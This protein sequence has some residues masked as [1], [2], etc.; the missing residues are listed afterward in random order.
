M[1]KYIGRKIGFAIAKEA[2]R[3]TPEADPDFW[4]PVM[5]VKHQNK[6]EHARFEAAIGTVYGASD[7]ELM[8]EWAEDGV[9]VYIGSEHFPLML[10]GLLGTLSTQVE[11]PEDDVHT[12]T[13]SLAET[14]QHQALTLFI[15]E[16]NGD[17]QFGLGVVSGIDINFERGKIL[18]YTANL[19]SKKGVSDT[20]TASVPSENIFRPQDFSVKIATNL[21]GLSGASAFDVISCNISFEKSIEPDDVLGDVAPQD[22]LNTVLTI[23]GSITLRYDANTYRDLMLANTH[24]AMRIKLTNTGVT[25]GLA[26]NPDIEI[27]LAKVFFTEDSF[28]RSLN[29]IVQETLNFEA[30]Y[31][32][33][34]SKF[35]DIIVINETSAY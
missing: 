1:T 35:G 15:D 31:S 34:D 30:L 4:L 26:S 2:V 24:R 19:I 22:F 14:S 11:T 17:Q 13:I 9:D 18:D 16:A 23:K 7:A 21:A 27:N 12:H 6:V 28:S 8:K 33:A 32:V 10:L 25:I 20:L 29:D 3:G 5:N